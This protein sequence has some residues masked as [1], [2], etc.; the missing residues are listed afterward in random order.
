MALFG[1]A[2]DI[3]FFRHINRELMGNIISQQCVYYK[4]DLGETKVNIYGE[5]SKG[6]Y[7]H[8]PV[9][10]NCLIERSEQQYPESD[11]GVN[12]NWNIIFKF[13]RDDLLSRN[14]CFNKNWQSECTYGANLVPEVGD[15]ILYNEGYYEVD[16]TNA[17]QYFV[18]KN[19]SYPQLDSDGNNALN[20]TDLADFGSSLSIICNTHY[21]PADKLA[22]SPFK[23]RM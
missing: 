4:Y 12:F 18:G 7:Y 5:A 14:E 22:L 6:K 20:E 13:L 1:E 19:P 17:N 11:L 2:R 16:T 23:E 15:V 10:L 9:Q 21:V 3:S 8:P